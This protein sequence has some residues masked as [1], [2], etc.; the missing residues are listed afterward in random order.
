MKRTFLALSLMF[1]VYHVTTTA[2]EKTLE[3]KVL[4]H[5]AVDKLSK[6]DLLKQDLSKVLAKTNRL[7]NFKMAKVDLY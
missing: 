3:P 5:R 7:E 6:S 1:G 2:V 4:E